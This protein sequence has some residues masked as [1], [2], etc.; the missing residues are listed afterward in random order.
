MKKLLNFK[1]TIAV[2]LFVLSSILFLPLFFSRCEAQSC[3][4]VLGQPVF[5][6]DFGAGADRGNPLPLTQTD[7]I[8]TDTY[9]L[10]YKQYSI[11]NN[12]AGF[13]SQWFPI[14]DHTGN[15]N[16]YMMIFNCAAVGDILYTNRLTGLCPNTTFELSSWLI[17]LLNKD[18]L[19]GIDANVTLSV[20]T[21]SGTVL[22]TFNS[23]DIPTTN[24][25]IWRNFKLYFTTPV[26]QTDIVIKIINNAPG[27]D[28]NDLAL[29]D[30]TVRPC[31]PDLNTSFVAQNSVQQLALCQGDDVTY[32]LGTNIIAGHQNPVY[33]W[34]VNAND[35]SGWKDLAGATATS[36]QLNFKSAL[37]GLYQYRLYSVQEQN[38]DLACCQVFSDTASVQ[39]NAKP[40]PAAT[41]NTPLCTGET[42]N[43]GVANGTS[44]QWTGPA[45]FT[46]SE[47]NPVIKNV[48]SAQAGMYQV[49]LTSA[50]GCV[51][52]DSVQVNL[53]PTTSF[54]AGA[55][56]SICQGSSTVLN[57][58][59]GISY[60]W[61]PA[62][63]LS[64][65]TVAN[66]AANPLITT[67]YHVKITNQFGCINTDSVTITITK[68]PIADAGM[69]KKVT[70][71]KSVLLSGKVQGDHYTYYWSPTTYLTN[72]NTLEPLVTPTE[73]ITYTLHVVSTLG[74]GETVDS[75]NVQVYQELNVP[76]TFSPNADG[77]ND[78][79]NII[80]LEAFPASITEVYN[81]YGKEIYRTSSN[82]NPWD[83]SFNGQPLP[84][85]TY[86]YKISNDNK[87]LKSGWVLIVR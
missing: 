1:D 70:A 61:Y 11:V 53:N 81:R 35:G 56:V 80:A 18:L 4:G 75:V 51:A 5:N 69:D 19:N 83:G 32:Q 77:V 25:P 57:A 63:G 9:G 37:P 8:Y 3:T 52:T 85:G 20:E 79:W 64:D 44:Y 43:L 12:T 29:D 17:S 62:T 14:N 59:G 72:A 13:Y 49:K 50:E 68:Q 74:C 23:G 40:I 30:I 67:V 22:N 82:N 24:T 6:V 36:V 31:Q 46:S 66:P 65:T 26:Q 2:K 58:S 7:Y 48:S 54:D 76:N 33:Q 16:G 38:K 42:L 45:G 55:D 34:Q 71:G 78:T 21:S 15:T 27:G 84:V 10:L 41:A 73:N 39:V 87:I 47:Q 60:R 28:G 86:F